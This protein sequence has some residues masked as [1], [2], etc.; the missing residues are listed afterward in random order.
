[1]KSLLRLAKH[2]LHDMGDRCCVSTLHDYNTVVQRIEDE[3][4]SFLT[5]TLSNFGKDLEKGLDQGYVDRHLFLGFSRKAELPRFL[6][7]FLGLVF[8]RTTGVLLDTPSID[9]IRSLRQFLLMWAKV[10]L[11]TTEKRYRRAMLGYIECEEGV[12]ASDARLEESQK[13]N[14]RRMSDLLWREI[15]TSIDLTVYN[16]DL[17]PKHGPGSTADKLFG[18]AKWNNRQWTERLEEVFPHTR[19]LFPNLGLYI[20]GHIEHLEPG[21]E[22]PVKVIAVP[23]T[24]KT[25]RIIA[26]EPTSMQYAQQALLR[27]FVKKFD[28]DKIARNFVR[29]L[30]QTPN[31]RM[32]L[33]G[34]FLENLATLD[35]SEAS[36]RVSYQ[37][38]LM[39]V[40]NHPWLA[41]AVD[42]CRSRKADVD[43][44][45]VIRLSKFASMGSALCFPFEA[46]VF[47]TVVFLGIEAALNTQLKRKDLKSFFGKVRV[48]GDDI[49]VP[50]EFAQSVVATLDLFGFKV[51]ASKSFWNGKFRESCGKDYYDGND[52]SIV[53]LRSLIPTQRKQARELASTV[54]FR[55][56]LF[57]AGYY[58]SVEY[59]DEIIERII[60]FPV[61]SPESPALG[62]LSH[63]PVKTEKWDS[64]L[65]RPLV[66][67]AVLV[68]RPSS[69]K[70]DDYGALMK[71]FLKDSEEPFI[72]R[73]HLEFAGRPSAVD[74]K[75]RWCSPI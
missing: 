2:V 11:E 47:C 40:R 75:L 73:N 3:G 13:D 58:R 26:V 36:D 18:N 6:G 45:G 15:F 25:P 64:R 29:F 4:L 41:K 27:E 61:V 28:D 16:E 22:I 72:D 53:R 70:L 30:D 59:L 8:D 5:I 9:A 21:A 23:K 50:V 71:W 48:Y 56:Q 54:S 68:P 31:Q 65:Q 24:Q 34:S 32:A 17:T 67:A 20:P 74:I 10:K 69:S 33:E 35:L 66:R 19:Y 52:V 46:M 44:H 60:P 55:N 51:N 49:I 43:G 39:M 62:R 57:L 42:A 14:F 37:H 7:G 38:V 12:R 1:M 63:D